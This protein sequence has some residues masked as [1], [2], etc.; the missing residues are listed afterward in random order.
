ML[1]SVES[2]VNGKVQTPR[3]PARRL[4]RVLVDTMHMFG[5]ESGVYMLSAKRQTVVCSTA[6]GDRDYSAEQKTHHFD[7]KGLAKYSK[8][9][10]CL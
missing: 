2:G 7:S 8:S 9:S 6:N 10:G 3:G 4:H 1:L 5:M